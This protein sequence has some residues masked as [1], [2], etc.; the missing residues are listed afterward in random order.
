MTKAYC[1]QNNG[2]C[3]TCSLVNYGRDCRNVSL[4]A[5]TLGKLGRS[6]N[7]EAQKNA[8]RDNG[9]LGGRP[10][11]DMRT[12]TDLD[13]ANRE[14]AKKGGWPKGKSRKTKEEV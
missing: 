11:K 5:S 3:E 1:T 2:D 12:I 6:K 4:A 9:K 13:K 8:S 14:N 10:K 7:T